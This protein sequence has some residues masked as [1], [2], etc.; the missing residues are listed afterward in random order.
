MSI[1]QFISELE[2]HNNQITFKLDISKY[3]S[4]D[5]IGKIFKVRIDENSFYKIVIDRVIQLD[6][7]VAKVKGRE[8]T[9]PFIKKISSAL[10][11]DK[12][13]TV[14]E[15]S[16]EYR[17]LDSSASA[18]PGKYSTELTPF[19]KEPLEAMTVNNGIEMVVFMKSAQVGY[20]ELLNNVIGYIIDISPCGTMVV[21]PTADSGKQ[22]SKERI[23][24]LISA[25]PRLKSKVKND[26][27]NSDNTV[28]MKKFEGGFAKIV[29]ANSAVNLRS[30]PIKILLFDEVDGYPFDVDNE[31]SPIDLAMK[32]TTTFKRRKILM[33]STPTIKNYS[34]IESYFNKGDKRHYNVPCPHCGQKQQLIMD[35]LKYRV[36]ANNSQIVDPNFIF[37]ECKHCK[38][39]IYESSKT[40]MLAQG[41]WIPTNPDAD[42]KIRSY[43][44]N[45]LY[46]PLGWKTWV[47]VAQE[48]LESKDDPEKLKTFTNTTLGLPYADAT[49]KPD[50]RKLE[51]RKS[52]FVSWN[53]PDDVVY[54]NA[55]V[56]TQDDRLA[57]CVVGYG[58]NNQQ[59]IINYE[60]IGG[61]PNRPEVWEKLK[62]L[63]DTPIKHESGVELFIKD[64][65]IDSGG[66]RTGYVYDFCRTNIEKFI[67]IKGRSFDSAMSLK[68][69]SAVDKGETASEDTLYIYLVNN[70]FNKKIIYQY[71]S[72][73]TPGRNYYYFN[74]D[75]TSSFFDMLCSE[76]R[77]IKKV[78]G[79]WR[80]E[81]TTSMKGER[82]EALDCVNYSLALARHNQIH[83]FLDERRY[84]EYYDININQ[85]KKAE[86][87]L[88]ENT[89]QP[90]RPPRPHNSGGGRFIKQSRY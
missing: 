11:P 14:R 6:K 76:E 29:G 88:I 56:D 13:L 75:L 8:L 10:R 61:D 81:F 85:K 1:E 40:K 69:S 36:L 34:N 25:T 38:E 27:K 17:Y 22:F 30:T 19:L 68:R 89:E 15:W 3:P 54:I 20:S 53:C 32:R 74:Q 59:Y 47:E 2:D 51:K 50:A 77:I 72:N 73:E 62:V 57:I 7:D 80:E 87:K 37:Y 65:A 66:H 63:I 12:T 55:G 86:S 52:N 42:K 16:D 83:K 24:P 43:H 23:A 33:G 26:V 28:M 90:R 18:M 9:P 21:L 82:N 35:N 39:R 64:L 78:Q 48:H 84:Q 4:D 70:N 58:K 60:E 79:E 44:I 46:S 31:G 67:P 41:E 49:H 5:L 71:L 45:S